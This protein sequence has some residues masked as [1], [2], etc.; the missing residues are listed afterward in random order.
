[1]QQ[2]KYLIGPKIASSFL[3]ALKCTLFWNRQVKRRFKIK[4]QQNSPTNFQTKARLLESYSLVVSIEKVD[5][6]DLNESYLG[7]SKLSVK[8]EFEH[9]MVHVVKNLEYY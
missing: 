7:F 8:V 5:V 3:I 6:W 2:N 1:M 9:E 4:A